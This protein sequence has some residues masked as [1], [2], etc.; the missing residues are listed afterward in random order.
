MNPLNWRPESHAA[1]AYVISV[2]VL[3]LYCSTVHVQY[4]ILDLHQHRRASLT[5]A[6]ATNTH[7][8]EICAHRH[9][10]TVPP[11]LGKLTGSHASRR[12]WSSLKHHRRIS[13]LVRAIGARLKKLLIRKAH[14]TVID[15]DASYATYRQDLTILFS[16]FIA[17]TIKEIQCLLET[18]CCNMRP[19]I[20]KKVHQAVS[21]HRIVSHICAHLFH[22]QSTPI[23]AWF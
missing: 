8:Y 20:I 5:T 15:G 23:V 16:N 18:S 14:A 10:D 2:F 1:P 3:V 11:E 7:S 4:G 17:S 13:P 19:W 21:A 6:T 12:V 9:R 22:L